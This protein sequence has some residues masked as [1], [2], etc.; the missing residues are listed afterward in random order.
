MNR[1]YLGRMLTPPLS[2][3]ARQKQKGKLIAQLDHDINNPLEAASG[4]AHML[5][6]D[7]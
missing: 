7:N 4:A 5:A 2:E 3:K 1:D 6:I